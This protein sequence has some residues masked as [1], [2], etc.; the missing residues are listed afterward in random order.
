MAV[1]FIAMGPMIAN[2][3]TFFWAYISGRGN[4]LLWTVVPTVISRGAL[5]FI[6]FVKSPLILSVILFIYFF[7]ET[8]HITPYSGLMKEIYPDNCRSQTMGYVRSVM[9]AA[10]LAG[11]FLGGKLLDEGGLFSYRWVF[12]MGGI[13]GVI[14]ALVFSL[15]RVPSKRKTGEIK[16]YRFQ[17]IT[18]SLKNI[19]TSKILLYVF[20]IE[21][22][23]GLSNLIAI[24]V[25]PLYLVDI[26]KLSNYQIGT[27]EVLISTGGMSFLY[28]WSRFKRGRVKFESFRN[29]I[30]LV[31]LIILLYA[32]SKNIYP[33]F[34]ASLLAGICWNG[35]DIFWVNYLIQ[36]TGSDTIAKGYVGVRYSLMGIRS[37]ITPLIITTIGDIRTALWFAFFLSV[38]G[39]ILSLGLNDENLSKEFSRKE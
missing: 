20:A 13:T 19:A 7:I 30:A 1:A 33:L 6:L 11:A 28:L 12:P 25:Y 24:G 18:K 29:I 9:I 17:S 5:V 14:S 4:N 39:I 36:N 26:L 16:P 27:L 34:I 37:S 10:T 35:W 3:A 15:I 2:S 8:I 23:I 21:F 31:P 22:I 38:T 32:V